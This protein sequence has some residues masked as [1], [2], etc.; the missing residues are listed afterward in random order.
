V[1]DPG[2]FARWLARM[3]GESVEL[4]CHPGYFDDTLVGRDCRAG[5]GLQQRRVDELSLLR[6]PAF[7]QSCRAAGFVLARPSEGMRRERRDVA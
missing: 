4:M 1:R 6:Q 2:F 3:P 5:D 7:L